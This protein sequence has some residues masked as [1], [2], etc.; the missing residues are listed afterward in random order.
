MDVIEELLCVI[1]Q[2]GARVREG[3]KLGNKNCC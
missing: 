3:E 1:R 2:T